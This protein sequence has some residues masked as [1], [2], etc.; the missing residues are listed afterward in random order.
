MLSLISTSCYNARNNADL[1]DDFL[2]VISNAK[3]FNPPL[4]LYHSEA[5]RLEAFGLEHISR[6]SAHVIEYE[7]DWTI[8]VVADGEPVASTSELPADVAGN[9]ISAV[10]LEDDA[11]QRAR[12]PSVISSVPGANAH[13]EKTRRSRS[14]KITAVTESWEKDGHLPGHKDGLGTFPPRSD[15]SELMFEL[16]LRG[17]GFFSLLATQFT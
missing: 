10:K 14:K 3:A 8:D 5:T 7:T 12:S 4:T 6:A 9:S 1:Q 13:A 16:K 17:S 11:A 15:L 2:L